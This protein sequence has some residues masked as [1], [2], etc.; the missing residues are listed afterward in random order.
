MNF[1]SIQNLLLKFSISFFTVCTTLSGMWFLT[2]YYIIT[3]SSQLIFR[4]NYF[5]ILNTIIYSMVPLLLFRH[6]QIMGYNYSYRLMMRIF[7]YFIFPKPFIITFIPSSFIYEL[8]V[9]NNSYC[10]KLRERLVIC[11][12]YIKPMYKRSA[13]FQSISLL[14][15]LISSVVINLFLFNT[16]A[17]YRQA[18]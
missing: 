16:L 6:Y 1:T 9:N 14:L 12:A 11:I 8:L 10:S 15:K 2:L 17:M 4:A 13:P 7:I 18:T 5:I 3:F